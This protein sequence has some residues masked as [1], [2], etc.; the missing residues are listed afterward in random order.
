MAIILSIETSGDIC[1]VALHNDGN[2]LD[3]KETNEPNSHGS[4]LGM[5][6]QD[7]LMAQNLAISNLKAIA[8]S[9]GPGSYTGLRIGVS[10]AKGICYASG[11]P[12]IAVNTLTSLSFAIKQNTP[13][14]PPDTM[15]M[16][17]IDA[18]RMEVYRAGYD[19]ELNTILP[20]APII[21]D[22]LFY[23]SLNLNTTYYVGGSGAQKAN[24]ESFK[25]KIIVLTE[26]VALS[27]RWIG[28]L[29]WTKF[30]EGQFE[31]IAYFEPVYLKEFAQ[32]LKK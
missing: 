31:D 29:A 15:I 13:N 23:D 28:A 12:L 10:L 2:L 20:T 24:K 30:R 26:E 14:L 17:M 22:E 19:R 8:V 1:S 18:R 11:I 7:I 5:F 6:I 9:E 4:K 21:L 3:A 27:S 32:I 16:P 25:G